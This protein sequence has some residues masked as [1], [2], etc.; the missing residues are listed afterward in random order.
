MRG[1]QR[2]AH[3]ARMAG[4]VA[5]ALEPI[6]CGGSEQVGEAVGAVGLG[7]HS[8]AEENHLAEAAIDHGLR[9]ADEVG[10]RQA[11]SRP[12]V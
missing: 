11:R 10:E 5:D 8:L 1:N 3:V 2:V 4:G 12:R 6:D 9:L 7:V